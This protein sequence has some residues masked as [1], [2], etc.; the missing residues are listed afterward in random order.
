MP[1]NHD[2]EFERRTLDTFEKIWIEINRIDKDQAV[3]KAR[4]GIAASCFGAVF[5]FA[6]ALIVHLIK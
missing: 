4:I 5:G 6:S 3:I 2:Y 1:P